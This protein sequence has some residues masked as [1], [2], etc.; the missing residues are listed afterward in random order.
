METHILSSRRAGRPEGLAPDLPT[1]MAEL[2]KR[3]RPLPGQ[4]WSAGQG[5]GW[6][7]QRAPHQHVW[8]R[9]ADGGGWDSRCSWGP[10]LCPDVCLPVVC[11]SHKKS[12]EEL[13]F[14]HDGSSLQSKREPGREHS[15]SRLLTHGSGGQGTPPPGAHGGRREQRPQVGRRADSA[16]ANGLASFSGKGKI[17]P[18]RRRAEDGH[19]GRSG[20]GEGREEV[21]PAG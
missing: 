16:V 15:L 2:G 5:W 11:L 18:G 1:G 4:V 10:S 12:S 19:V 14:S 3:P 8:A 21:R 6:T 20:G 9:E 13:D 17:R 7:L